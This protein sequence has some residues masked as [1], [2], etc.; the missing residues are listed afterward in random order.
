MKD[1]YTLKKCCKKSVIPILL[2]LL[3]S[4]AKMYIKTNEKNSTKPMWKIM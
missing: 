3:F 4:H 2:A 1:L